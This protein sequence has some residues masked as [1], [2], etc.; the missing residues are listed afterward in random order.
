[1]EAQGQR[2][3]LLL[4]LRLR[5]GRDRRVRREDDPRPAGA[6]AGGGG[7]AVGAEGLRDLRGGRPRPW[8]R[9]HLDIRGGDGGAGRCRESEALEPLQVRP[10]L[11][12]GQQHL[13]RG[14]DQ[15]HVLPQVR[16][17][18]V[19]SRGEC[20]GVALLLNLSFSLWCSD[21]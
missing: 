18:E 21:L 1:M 5:R 2:R 13:H 12:G 15:G 16:E 8:R 20:L 4:V 3:L 19:R 14:P 9:L 10:E 11:R 17:R 7:A 6:A